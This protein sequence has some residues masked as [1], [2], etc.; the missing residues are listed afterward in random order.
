MIEKHVATVLGYVVFLML[1]GIPATL[2]DIEVNYK[3][4]LGFFICL[5]VYCYWVFYLIIDV[6]IEYVK[7]KEEEG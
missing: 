6:L 4:P 7:S 2:L 1:T 3:N 5:T